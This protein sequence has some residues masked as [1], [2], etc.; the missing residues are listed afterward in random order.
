MGVSDS[1]LPVAKQNTITP[2]PN[3]HNSFESSKILSTHNCLS[4]NLKEALS[5]SIEKKNTPKLKS[6]NSNENYSTKQS[7]KTKNNFINYQINKLQLIKGI[8]ISK[9]L[10]KKQINNTLSKTNNVTNFNTSNIYINNSNKNSIG[11]KKYSY[12]REDSEK[13]LKTEK[14]KNININNIN[15]HNKNIKDVKPFYYKPKTILTKESIKQNKSYRNNKIKIFSSNE[16][17]KNGTGKDSEINKIKDKLRS[18]NVSIKNINN[19]TRTEIHTSFNKATRIS[20]YDKLNLVNIISSNSYKNKKINYKLEHAVDVH[21]YYNNS[22]NKPLYILDDIIDSSEKNMNSKKYSTEKDFDDIL[23][24][25]KLIENKNKIYA[26]LLKLEERKWQNDLINIS[27]IINIIRTSNSKKQ[28]ISINNILYKILNLFDHFN[29][30]L[31]S[32]GFVFSSIVYENKIEGINICEINDLPLPNYDSFFWFKGFKWKG[33]YIRIEKDINC[34]NSI[35]KE[36]KALNYFFLDYIHIIWNNELLDDMDVN[37]KYNIL[38]NDI[39]FPLIGYCQINSFVLIVSS[40]IKP[41]LNLFNLDDIIEQSNGKIELFSKINI[42]ENNILENKMKNISKYQNKNIMK[43]A[44]KQ[45]NT[46]NLNNINLIDISKKK[47]LFNK[48]NHS[49]DYNNNNRS[50][51]KNSNKMVEIIYKIGENRNNNINDITFFEENYYIND[52]LNSKLFSSINKNNFIKVKGGK[53][54]LVDVSKY[55]PNLFENK[56]LNDI[57]KLNFYGSVNGEKKYFTLNYNSSSFISLKNILEKNKNH[58][59]NSDYFNTLT[60]KNILEKIYKLSSSLNLKLKNVTIGNMIFRILYLNSVKSKK[61]TK[62]YFVDFLFNYD[63]EHNKNSTKLDNNYLNISNKEENENSFIYIQEPYVIIYDIIEPIKLDYSLIKSIK[64]KDNKTEV[65]NNIFF[66]RTNYIDYF[67]SWCD[68]F[69]RNSFNIKNYLDLKYY[70]R[71][72][73]INQNL[74]IFALI[75]INNEEISDIIYIHLLV[76]AIKFVCFYKDN[77][78]VLNK[79]QKSSKSKYINLS[80]NLKFKI[81]FYIKS[82]LYPNE[83]LPSHQN[84]FKAIFEQ[85]LFYSNIL[86]FKYKL[87]DDYLSL[88]L[89]NRDKYNLNQNKNL[90]SFFKIESPQIFLQQCILISRKKPFL[91]LSEL[92]YKLNFLIDPFIKFKS[93]ISIE[94]MSKKLEISNLNIN[95]IIIKSFIDSNEIS[96]LLLTKLIKKY[97]VKIHN[98]YNENLR[99][100]YKKSN[101]NNI[102]NKIIDH[103][104]DNINNNN[105]KISNVIYFSNP[106]LMPGVANKVN[107]LNIMNN[108]K[109]QNNLDFENFSD[110]GDGNKT[111]ISSNNNLTNNNSHLFARNNSNNT[112]A[113]INDNNYNNNDMLTK[114]TS[115]KTIDEVTSSNTQKTNLEKNKNSKN[116]NNNILKIEPIDF[117]EINEKIIF[118]LPPNCHKTLYNYEINMNSND[119]TAKY[120]YPNLSQYYYIKNIN[121]IKDWVLVNENIF[122]TIYNS[123]N[124]RYENTLIKSYI[125]LF[126]YYYYIEKSRK[127]FL[128]ISNKILSLFKSNIPYQLTLNELLIINIILALSNNNNYVKSEEFFSKSVMLLLMNFGDPRGRHNDSHGL[129]QFPLW[130]IAR[131]MYKLEEPIINENFKEMYQALDFFEKNKGIY[132]IYMGKNR[133]MYDFNY[134]NNIRFNLDKLLIMN[135]RGLNN[136]IRNK[137]NNQGLIDNESIYS[138]ISNIEENPNEYN[139]NKDLTEKDITLCKIYFD[140]KNVEKLCIN[141]YLFPSISCKINNIARVFYKKEFI[142]YIIK[143]ILSLY[144]SR[145]TIYPKNYLDKKISDE[146]IIN[147]NLNIN[148]NN[149]SVNPEVTRKNSMNSDKNNIKTPLKAKYIN[150]VNFEKKI[151]YSSLK[152]NNF[153][154]KIEKKF[155]KRNIISGTPTSS[156]SYNDGFNKKNINNSPKNNKVNKNINNSNKIKKTISDNNNIITNY[157]NITN[158]YKNNDINNNAI[159]KTKT[160]KIFSHF[161]YKELFQKL[162]YKNNLPSGIIISFGNNKHNETSHDHYEKLTLPR[163]IFKLKNEIIDKIYSGWEHNIVLNNKGEIFSFGHNQYYQCGL[164]NSEKFNNKNIDIIPDPTNISKIYSNIKATKVSC[165]NEHTLIISNDKNIYGFGSNE[166][167]LLGISENKIKTY[168]PTK[169]HFYGNNKNEIYDGRMIDISCGT[170]HNLALTEDGK[171]FSWGSIQGGQLGFPS[172]FLINMNKKLNSDKNL[173]LSTPTIIPFF[174]KNNIEIVKISSGEAHSL[175]LNNKGKAYSW[176]FGSNGQLG[177]GFCEDFF[178]PGEGFIK[179]RIFEP[180]LINNFK[181]NKPNNSIKKNIEIKEIKCGKTFSMFINENSELFASGNN[182][183]GQLGFKDLEKKDDLYNPEIQCDDYVYPTLLRFENKKVEKISCGEVHCLAIVKDINSNIQS[184]WSWGN[185][186]FGQIGHGMM[187][188]ISLPKEVEYLS[189]YKMNNFSDISCGGFHSLV[190]LKNKNNLEWIE[191]DYDIYILGILN[192]IGDL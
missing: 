12:A 52:L 58:K 173:Y 16:I 131:K 160:K 87:I 146:L 42:I 33:L 188:K 23:R 112:T 94:S 177:L 158:I 109:N 44:Q 68:M 105:V 34:I 126:L 49:I 81:L 163:F 54:I 83:I 71:K 147:N 142:I 139:I 26:E 73:G 8:N 1:S 183:L 29:W 88:G 56:F 60:P 119:K 116:L 155:N 182:D 189:E 92:E 5:S 19:L 90:Y 103:G 72:F 186:K 143:E 174:T 122:K 62:K 127:D 125:F 40:I 113:F 149:T 10:D 140:K 138:M 22:K 153:H 98:I 121:I 168:T 167:G 107:Y 118:V 115:D 46:H 110:K 114:V 15:I 99:D 171:V 64:M 3:H 176:G 59:K 41:E 104:I 172:E 97:N 154:H 141:H 191:K 100:I 20:S 4:K 9:T 161:L 145:G 166:G 28:E 30:L 96:G 148:A 66:L 159:S 136:N 192:E 61:N 74:L 77:E 164:P 184:I 67:M 51:N 43:E 156:K 95:N 76:K 151:P 129:L 150:S 120:L 79:L 185:N 157:N 170:V 108:I 144:L 25:N 137:N 180:Q 178:E 63:L 179:S 175:A 82:I 48:L 24:N 6:A 102:N 117:K 123:N 187:V 86:F 21:N 55:L 101:D 2:S 181:D 18:N 31:N 134:M 165:G 93:S 190:L 78:F 7:K 50:E 11:K 80:E 169:I 111:D 135:D 106:N 75:K 124:F 39:I 13:I 32:I 45:N 85:L 152:E 36:I 14:V 35:K 37:Y 47:L 27:K 17:N 128:K 53:Y 132:N 70:M 57:K 89:L 91:F 162:S 38:S 130:E 84:L 65:I 133:E 69:N